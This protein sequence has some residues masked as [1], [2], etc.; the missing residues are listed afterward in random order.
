MKANA[1]KRRYQQSNRVSEALAAA[2]K[3]VARQMQL[4]EHLT[5]RRLPTE[6][7]LRELNTCN[8]ALLEIRNHHDIMAVLLSPP[9]QGN[10]DTE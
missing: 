7:A 5:K 3:R 10:R 2:E 1:R 6:Q 4:I 8:R 9:Q